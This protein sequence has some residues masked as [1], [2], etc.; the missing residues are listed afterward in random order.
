MTV[1][2]KLFTPSGGVEHYEFTEMFMDFLSL[3]DER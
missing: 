1:Y 3:A 2:T